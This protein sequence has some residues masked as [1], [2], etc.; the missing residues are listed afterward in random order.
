MLQLAILSV[1]RFCQPDA[2]GNVQSIWKE[3]KRNF[4]ASEMRRQ[5]AECLERVTGDAAGVIC[6]GQ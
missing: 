4:P 3:V 6:L 5:P 2:S 1:R